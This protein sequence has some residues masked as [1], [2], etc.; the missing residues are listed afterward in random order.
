[1]LMIQ[2]TSASAVAQ[3]DARAASPATSGRSGASVQAD[4]VLTVRRA[5]GTMARLTPAQLRALPRRT[6]QATSH[7]KTASY[8]GSDV[9]AVLAAAA[10]S[11]VAPADSLRGPGVALVLVATGA[12]GYRASFAL[13]ELD[14]S[15]GGRAVLV[16]DRENGIP[17]PAADGPWRL[18]VASDARPSRWVHG[19]V[20][21]EVVLPGR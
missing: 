17:L 14:P 11:G 8:E 6:V 7:G 18:V 10:V 2:L 21:L 16:V 19:L 20:R 9:R 4:S 3:H 13:A 1:M 12:D 15:I 5:D